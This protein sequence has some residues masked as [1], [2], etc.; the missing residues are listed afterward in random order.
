MSSQGR[1]GTHGP[2][3]G[4]AMTSLL[5]QYLDALRGALRSRAELFSLEAQRAADAATRM[6]VLGGV[7]LI[8]GMT[9]WLLLVTTVVL[10][11]A[12]AGLPLLAALLLVF[13][14]HVVTGFVMVGRVRRLG[15]DFQFSATRRS[16]QDGIVKLRP[17]ETAREGTH[18]ET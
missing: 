6:A 2:V 13:V 5:A 3:P 18:A 9:G 12:A 11:L 4:E 14:V 15:A 17:G 10:G 8:V 1:L 16:L 7:L